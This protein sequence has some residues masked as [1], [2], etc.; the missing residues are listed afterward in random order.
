MAT[1]YESIS[2]Q[3]KTGGGG[4]EKRQQEEDRRNSTNRN[5]ITL[6]QLFRLV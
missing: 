2:K 5:F 6:D 1:H 4:E 3:R